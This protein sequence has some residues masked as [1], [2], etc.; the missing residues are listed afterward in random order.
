MKILKQTILMAGL[1][2]ICGTAYADEKADTIV[3]GSFRL[4]A[5]LSLPENAIAG[6][7]LVHGSGPNDRDETLMA[8]HPFKDIAEGLSSQGIAV[9]RYDKRTFVYKDKSVEAGKE[10]TIDDEVTD[11]AIAAVLHLKKVL[12]GK[13]VFVAGHSLGAMMAPRIAELCPEV[14][15][16]ILLAAPARDLLTLAGEQVRYLLGDAATDM[17]VAQVT[18]QMKASAPDSYW[19]SL[20]AYDQLKTAQKLTLPILQIHGG[21]DYQVPQGDYYMWSLS[22][23]GK[24][25]FKQLLFPTLNHLM[26][27]G[28]GPSTPQEYSVEKTVAKEVINSMAAFVKENR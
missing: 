3:S 8:C 6:V 25:Q 17:A 23:M 12:N 27:P 22:M 10:L 1:L 20:D 24:K 18:E 21:R 16:L 9:L 13:P 11:D 15:G 14:S 26:I 2:L 28:E 19:K 4:P 7:V 5:T